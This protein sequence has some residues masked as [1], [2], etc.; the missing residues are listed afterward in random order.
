V[1]TLWWKYYELEMTEETN[2][3]F[4][5]HL[6]VK[7]TLDVLTTIGAVTINQ[8]PPT[9]SAQAVWEEKVFGWIWKPEDLRVFLRS[10][11]TSVT[12]D[13]QVPVLEEIALHLPKPLRNIVGVDKSPHLSLPWTDSEHKVAFKEFL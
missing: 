6:D 9:P 10:D 4:V 5:D 11:R 1:V 7:D 3:Q 13:L 8:P 12:F 2:G